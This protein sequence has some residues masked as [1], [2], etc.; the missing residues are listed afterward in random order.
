M[1]NIKDLIVKYREL[2][3]DLLNVSPVNLTFSQ[4]F[5]KD[6]MEEEEENIADDLSLDNSLSSRNEQEMEERDVAEYFLGHLDG[7]EASLSSQQ[8]IIHYPDE[9]KYQNS[10]V[11][12]LINNFNYSLLAASKMMARHILYDHQSPCI[13]QII[14]VIQDNTEIRSFTL[15]A[16]YFNSDLLFNRQFIKALNSAANL[17]YICVEIEECDSVDANKVCDYLSGKIARER[18]FVFDWHDGATFIKNAGASNVD[19]FMFPEWDSLRSAAEA[20]PEERIT[21]T[22][23]LNTNFS[24]KLIY[25]GILDGWIKTLGGSERPNI[26]HG[27]RRLDYRQE[28]DD[29]RLIDYAAKNS[30]VLVI[31]Q[32]NRI[33]LGF[34]SKIRGEFEKN[35]YNWNQRNLAIQELE[36]YYS[37][38]LAIAVVHGSPDT[39][40]ALLDLSLP[41]PEGQIVIDNI[42]RTQLFKKTSEECTLL[43]LASKAG[44]S[45]NVKL[46]LKLRLD[47]NE[48]SPSIKKPALQ[49]ALD[50]SH[51]ECAALLLMAGAKFP[52]DTS[53]LMNDESLKVLCDDRIELTTIIQR[54]GFEDV[55]SQI[56]SGRLNHLFLSIENKSA[57]YVA[58]ISENYEVYAFL[59]TKGFAL[60]DSE[61]NEVIHNIRIETATVRFMGRRTY[62]TI[63]FMLSK[64]RVLQ[65]DYSHIE[66]LQ[67]L[68]KTLFDI[69]VISRILQ[70]IEY[71]G[72]ALDII[73][74]FASINIDNIVMTRNMTAAGSYDGNVGRIYIAGK[75]DRVELLGTMAHEFTHFVMEILYRN[76]GHPHF[77]GDNLNKSR[78]NAA[79]I[80]AKQGG[81]DPIIHRVFT[82]YPKNEDWYAEI[83]VRV[84]HILAKYGDKEGSRILMAKTPLL[85]AFYREVIE[86][87][88]KEKINSVLQCSARGRETNVLGNGLGEGQST[89]NAPATDSVPCPIVL[90]TSNQSLFHQLKDEECL[91]NDQPGESM[92]SVL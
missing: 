47:P 68:Y 12:Y 42:Q 26:L 3:L 54:N 27:I 90:S 41:L 63:N 18:A 70:V 73:F 24:I 40:I 58:Y 51:Y 72:E 82:C 16:K 87:A 31:N 85:F 48:I 32:L 17:H 66:Y 20:E 43:Q 36:I 57:P 65:P 15:K 23:D 71:S 10:N 30:N 21:I 79:I 13:H 83:I 60:L 22:P 67:D 64:S 6:E 89:S 35:S 52:R 55:E 38:S 78:L 37:Q 4:L 88:C 62:S 34:V 11:E 14:D 9:Y 29:W 28:F 19:V 59:L 7:L 56:K 50:E 80:E 69:P 84:P 86:V 53:S 2:L 1:Q 5:E 61:K 46:L 39:I 33:R 81:M 91:N 75:V 76:N 49:F 92:S 77:P 74:D 25:Q 8:I 44:K 45:A